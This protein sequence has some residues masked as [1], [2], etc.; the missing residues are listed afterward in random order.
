M[1]RLR[2]V[3]HLLLLIPVKH[4][5]DGTEFGLMD[6]I[7]ALGG[8]EMGGTRMQRCR[9][10]FSNVSRESSGSKISQHDLG[11]PPRNQSQFGREAA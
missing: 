9:R 3:T 2:L 11:G 7:Q 4:I 5:G 1:S 8:S 10:T 6:C